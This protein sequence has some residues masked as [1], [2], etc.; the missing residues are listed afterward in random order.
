MGQ[1][2]FQQ[3]WQG[4]RDYVTWLR[5]D[6]RT[7]WA[8]CGFFVKGYPLD[9]FGYASIGGPRIVMDYANDGWG[10]DN[11]DRV[12]AH[13]TGHIFQ[14]PDEYASSGCNCGGSLGHAS[15]S[16]TPTARTAPA[17]PA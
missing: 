8:Y 14:C 17:R 16:R 15:A 11:I 5:N 6:R 12:F 3:N 9:H 4:V 7:N 2:G 1:L 13:E 10:P